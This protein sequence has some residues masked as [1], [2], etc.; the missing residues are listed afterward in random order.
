[1]NRNL[2]LVFLLLTPSLFSQ[3]Y[4]SQTI[5]SQIFFSVL[6]GTNFHTIPTAGTA[7]SFEVKSNI[8]SNLNAKFSIG[9]SVIFDDNSYEEKLSG[10]QDFDSMYHTR[11]L[12]VD[13][14]NY[15]IIPINIGIE[16]FFIENQITPFAIFEAGYNFSNSKI[17]GT[18]HDGIAGSYE[19]IEEVPEEY[20]N[21]AS[22][23]DDGSSIALGFGIGVRYKINERVD[24]NIRY[25]YRY[26]D[27]IVNNNQILVGFT[28]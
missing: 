26:N 5:F 8:A 11:L 10:F 24:F 21:S 13:R 1:M 28:F 22:V 15:T 25:V 27:A 2:A 18:T 23:L 14:I 3:V 19:T 16:Y 4:K 9:Y 17:E 6:A 12:I 7:I 20:R